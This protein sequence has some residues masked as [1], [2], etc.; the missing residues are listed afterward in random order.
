MTCREWAAP[1]AAVAL[2][3]RDGGCWLLDGRGGR[4]AGVTAGAFS[5]LPLAAD[6][7]EGVGGSH[8]APTSNTGRRQVPE[9][10]FPK[11][12]LMKIDSTKWIHR[13]RYF[14]R[15]WEWAVPGRRGGWRVLAAGRP[16][17]TFSRSDGGR[18]QR[19]RARRRCGRGRLRRRPATPAGARALRA[20]D[21]AVQG[22]PVASYSARVR[23]QLVLGLVDLFPACPGASLLEFAFAFG[24]LVSRTSVALV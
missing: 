7:G 6:A 13:W 16:G 14:Q 4:S 22:R 10:I 24:D 21:S 18:I 23:F 11:S 1:G 15:M 9:N 5:A 19:R 8:A 12:V 17:R 20:V 2:E 3:Q